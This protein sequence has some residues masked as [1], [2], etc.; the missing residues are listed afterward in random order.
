MAHVYKAALGGE[1]KEGEK[2]SCRE[3]IQSDGKILGEAVVM[4]NQPI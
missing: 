4:Y 1:G 2:E 3:E